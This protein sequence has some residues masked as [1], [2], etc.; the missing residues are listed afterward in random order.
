MSELQIKNRGE[1]EAV[2]NKAPK[3]SDAP[4]GFEPMTSVIQVQ[5]STN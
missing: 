1:R 5:C 4:T 3:I 2:T